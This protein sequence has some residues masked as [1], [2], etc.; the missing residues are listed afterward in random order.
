[1]FEFIKT[2]KLKTKFRLKIFTKLILGF[3][4]VLLSFLTA[5]I[6]IYQMLSQNKELT[7][8]VNNDIVPSMSNLNK[9][10]SIVF[11]S[12]HLLKNWGLFEKETNTPE[13]LR[14]IKINQKKY[15][16]T[17]SALEQLSKNWNENEQLKLE[18][19][20]TLTD[21]WFSQQ[22]DLMK[23]LNSPE[24]YEESNFNLKFYN[25]VQEGEPLMD[26]GD[27][28]KYQIDEMYSTKKN[29]LLSY[30]NKMEKSFLTFTNRII[31]SGI[32]VLIMVILIT[33]LFVNSMLVPL[34]S[35]RRII[36]SM[37]E[38]ELPKKEIYTSTDEIGQMGKVLNELII[39]LRQKAEFA[40]EIEGGNF[41]GSFNVS[42][43]KDLL[44][45][46]L[47]AMRNSLAEAHKHESL[48][49]KENEE[50]SWITQGI[51]EFNDI[52]RE[53]SGTQEQ[54]AL[55]SINKLTRYTNSQVGG[56]YLLNESDS[57]NIFLELAAFYA[58][59]R[60]KFFEEKILPGEN[61]I[62]QCYY[63]KDTIF[64]TDIP[65][66]Y[67]K[68][69]SGL[70]KEDARSL[71]IVPLIYNNKIYGII[72][73]ASINVFEPYQIE[74]VERVG[75]ILA[76]TI[77]NIRLN[78]QKS[79]FIDETKGFSKVRVVSENKLNIETELEELISE[80]NEL[81][82]ENEELRKQLKG[83]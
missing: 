39:G 83:I 21:S 32:I 65:S 47:L 50:R 60:H 16:D 72:E 79:H 77:S 57:E 37:S 27:N 76:S 59:D 26:L 20:F 19:V 73:L 41:T 31:I 14:L 55:T 29:I 42:S 81:I 17:K 40:K 53:H 71:I 51:S 45:N 78:K 74:F 38:G 56:F 12:K 1:M 64:L 62:G 46:S 34:N 35:I 52:I 68:I 5:Y 4:I 3:S 2:K 66:G 33:F 80:N 25:L 36:S 43:K 44:G 24:K 6:F 22:K 10:S 49:R 18:Q 70:G 8:K 61:L 54:F 69:S 11:E 28:I 58:Y 67:I 30:N 15:I 13:K 9:L 48:R 7:H 82:K 63:E 75:E 23:K